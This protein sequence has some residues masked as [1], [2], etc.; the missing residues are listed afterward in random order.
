MAAPTWAQELVMQVCEDYKR[1]KPTE[2]R[3]RNMKTRRSSSGHWNWTQLYNWRNGSRHL[4]GVI[5][6]KITISAGTT[7]KDHKEVLLHEL[8][9]HIVA[10]TRQGRKAGHPVRFWKLHYELC[11]RYGVEPDHDRNVRYKAKAEQGRQAAQPKPDGGTLGI[12]ELLQ[13]LG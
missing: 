11:K 12:A 2:F 10:K 6:T 13:I 8:A 5:Q 4:R 1:A 3:W 7:G 9:H